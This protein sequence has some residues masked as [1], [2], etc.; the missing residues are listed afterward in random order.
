MNSA[1]SRA[2]LCILI[3]TLSALGALAQRR[4][5]ADQ[6]TPPVSFTL[7]LPL[8]ATVEG[9]IALPGQQDRFSL[10]LEPG[11]RLVFDALGQPQASL[12]ARLESPSA[13]QLWEIY[14]H[15]DSPP[16]YINE[17]GIHTLVLFGWNG[18]TGD[19]RF[20]MLDLRQS[21]TIEV[22]DLVSG[23]LADPTQIQ[24][25]QFTG[26]TGQRFLFESVAAHQ[27]LATWS[28]LAPFDQ[29]LGGAHIASDLGEVT[30]PVSGPYWLLVQGRPD[31]TGP[32]DFRI[33]ASLVSNPSGLPSGFNVIHSGTLQPGET[34]LYHYTAPAGTAVYFDA[35]GGNASW[36]WAELRTPDGEIVL[37]TWGLSD[38]GPVTLP[39]SGSYTLEIRATD[40]YSPSSY[41][42][43]LLDLS[44]TALT[45]YPCT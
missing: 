18:A 44:S 42:V 11:Q 36:L 45:L 24:A 7:P 9:T 40:A 27:A 22:D 6:S 32:L 19:Y 8:A 17:P 37:S 38:F 12:R 28:L 25:Y 39:L 15:D 26:T 2:R 16:I 1:P 34:N 13:R 4:S 3:L 29:V 20:R 10:E 23:Q 21:E 35:L 41:S 33:R 43:Q 14:A 5:I 31:A 30:L